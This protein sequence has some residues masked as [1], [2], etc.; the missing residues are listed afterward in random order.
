MEMSGEFSNDTLLNY[1]AYLGN[2]S[3][4]TIIHLQI[5]IQEGREGGEEGFHSE[6]FWKFANVSWKKVI[7]NWYF[8]VCNEEVTLNKFGQEG[9]KTAWNSLCK[10]EKLNRP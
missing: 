1:W 5:D 2:F 9:D 4:G 6:I 7:P 8:P 10:V 3:F